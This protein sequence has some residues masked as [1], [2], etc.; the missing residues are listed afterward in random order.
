LTL[1]VAAV[2]MVARDLAWRESAVRVPTGASAVP[3]LRRLPL[4]KHERPPRGLTESIDRGFERVIIEAGLDCSPLAACLLMV[5]AGLVVGG[6]ATIVC[7]DLLAGAIGAV[8]AMVLTLAW[9]LM[10][11]ARRMKLITEQLPDVVDLLARAVRAG[12]S[13]EQAIELVG[14]KAAQPLAT[15]FIRVSRH[16]QMGLSLT[17]AMRALAYRVRLLEARLLTNTL[18]VHHQAGG[19]VSHSLDRMAVVMRERLAFRRQLRA[20]TAAGRFSAI[21]VA[22]IGPLLF[23]Y[24]FLFQPKYAGS[25]LTLPIGQALLGVAVALELVG[26]A[27]VIRLLRSEY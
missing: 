10:L 17:A 12:E 2:V 16:L 22:S 19:N 6:I 23:G 5:L 21:M 9:L 24:M 3:T 11:Q 18:T 13:L 14:Q 1:L 7:D 8:L 4:A 26:L 27:W 25:L 15:E 20:T